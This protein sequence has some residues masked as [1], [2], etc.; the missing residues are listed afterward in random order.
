[1]TFDLDGVVMIV[2][3]PSTAAVGDLAKDHIA[4]LAFGGMQPHAAS[5]HVEDPNVLILHSV[6]VS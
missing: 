2:R 6:K 3:F 1:M 4:G 5:E